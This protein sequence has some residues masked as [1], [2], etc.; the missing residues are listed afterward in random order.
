MPACKRQV[1][2]PCP[3]L[4]TTTN[5]FFSFGM[6]NTRSALSAKSPP[7]SFTRV[8]LRTSRSM[9]LVGPVAPR[10]AARD[11][12]RRRLI[13][14][15]GRDL[16]RRLAGRVV[17]AVL[18]A[19]IRR[20]LYLAAVH[21]LNVRLVG[22]GELLDR[23]GDFFVV[24]AAQ[25]DLLPL[26]PQQLRLHLELSARVAPGAHRAGRRPLILG[27]KRIVRVARRRALRLLCRQSGVSHDGPDR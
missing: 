24:V 18:V 15:G 14:I 4:T 11:R 8:G 13:Q 12:N 2:P 17:G 6:N 23:H 25:H 7:S 3:E 16:D 21:I 19:A 9:A 5:A 26:D 20:E 10:F 27:G 1:C 22:G